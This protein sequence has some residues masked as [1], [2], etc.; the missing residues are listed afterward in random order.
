V[1][2]KDPPLR[3]RALSDWPPSAGIGRADAGLPLAQVADRLKAMTHKAHPSG[4][5]NKNDVPITERALSAC[6]EFLYE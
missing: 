6:Q 5:V 3:F 2:S 4:H 1:L